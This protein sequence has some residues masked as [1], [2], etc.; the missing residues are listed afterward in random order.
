VVPDNLTDPEGRLLH[1]G[2][3]L[4]D[5]LAAEAFD[6][7]SLDHRQPGIEL[8]LTGSQVSVQRPVGFRRKSGDLLFTLDHQAQAGALHPAAEY[9]PSRA[10]QASGETR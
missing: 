7:L 6:L 2:H 1:P 4:L 3:Q 8:N 9:R 5:L 10:S